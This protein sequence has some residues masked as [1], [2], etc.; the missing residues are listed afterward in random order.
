MKGLEDAISMSVVHPTWQRTRPADPADTHCGWH[1]AAAGNGA[2]AGVVPPTGV[3]LIGNDGATIDHVNGAACVRDL[4]DLSNDTAGKYTVPIL[5][6]KKTGAIVNNESSEIIRML[7]GPFARLVGTDATT[8]DLFPGDLA[9]AIEAANEWIYPNI[10]NGVYRCG[11]AKTQQA[12]DAAVA[13]LGG[14]LDRLE[15]LLAK[16]RCAIGPVVGPVAS[17]V[18]ACRRAGVRKSCLARAALVPWQWLGCAWAEQLPSTHARRRA[19][20][21]PA[22]NAGGACTAARRAHTLLAAADVLRRR[23]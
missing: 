17:G 13:D 15:A 4:Y 21:A 20:P 8:P 2:K 16:Q 22:R 3:G 14:A 23:H 11:F 1:F 7:N 12:Y 19:S 5:W 10:N 18:P 9:A 6:D